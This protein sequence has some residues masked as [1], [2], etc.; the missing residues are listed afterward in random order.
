MSVGGR[1]R[2]GQNPMGCNSTASTLPHG[3]GPAMADF[4]DWSTNFE[5]HY[6]SRSQAAARRRA[7]SRRKPQ[8]DAAALTAR[9]EAAKERL[10][11]AFAALHRP[12]ASPPC[13][14]KAIRTKRPDLTRGW[15]TDTRRTFKL[16]NGRSRGIVGG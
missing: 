6:T 9:V 11:G 5:A 2:I 12:D 8:V 13:A 14:P 4:G 1:I 16:C 10:R 15:S 7:K 3:S